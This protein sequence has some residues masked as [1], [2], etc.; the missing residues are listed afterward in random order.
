M[1]FFF[2]SSMSK[3][4]IRLLL[5]VHCMVFKIKPKQIILAWSVLCWCGT[6]T[7]PWQHLVLISTRR[8][9]Y[10]PSLSSRLVRRISFL[11]LPPPLRWVL[12][13]MHRF[14]H[15]VLGAHSGLG[16]EAEGSLVKPDCRQNMKDV[17][18]SC[19]KLSDC[20]LWKWAL[21][22]IGKVCCFFSSTQNE[23][24]LNNWWPC[25]AILIFKVPSYI[26]ISWNNRKPKSLVPVFGN[27]SI[28]RCRLEMLH[29]R[30]MG[31]TL[32]FTYLQSL[33]L[34]ACVE[35][36]VNKSNEK[37]WLLFSLEYVTTTPWYNNEHCKTFLIW[38][39]IAFW[40]RKF[41][42]TQQTVTLI[43]YS[44]IWFLDK[45]YLSLIDCTMWNLNRWAMH[46]DTFVTL[47]KIIDTVQ[48]TISIQ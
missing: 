35:L 9:R 23:S 33:T 29:S 48:F 14:V 34:E 43:N 31:V 37:N 45:P 41:T 12:T 10:W 44:W 25:W 42:W 22:R 16:W 2:F 7:L 40:W 32:V 17:R 1:F 19:Q 5:K 4:C 13:G 3:S 15:Q 8:C 18:C 39:N 21:L 26:F 24:K 27:G 30:V 20:L 47:N 36:T 11:S 6:R 28:H 38:F 46:Y